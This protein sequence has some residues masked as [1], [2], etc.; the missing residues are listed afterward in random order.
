MVGDRLFFRLRNVP[1][2]SPAFSLT[3]H[4][5]ID[6]LFVPI[7]G[8]GVLSS[9]TAHKLAV[10]FEPKIIIPSHFQDIGDKSSLKMF[11]KEAGE[12]SIKAIDKLTLKKKDLEGKE[13][14]V[15]VLEQI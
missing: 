11:L 5:G 1:I 9:A 15:I 13:A 2:D 6:V 14:D 10:Q 3:S 8:D 12:E 7:G 4:D